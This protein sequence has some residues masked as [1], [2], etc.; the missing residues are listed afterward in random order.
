MK[1][2]AVQILT[3]SKLNCV[4]SHIS[5]ALEECEISADEYKLILEEVEK[6]HE[7][8]E[9]IRHKNEPAVGSMINEK[10]KNELIK[11][12]RDQAHTSFIK[13]L[14]QSAASESLS[15]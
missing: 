1:L 7:M 3:S 12:G 10:S 15:H 11:C 5:K 13:K 9:E 4:Y 6:Y 2:E 14:A 8:K